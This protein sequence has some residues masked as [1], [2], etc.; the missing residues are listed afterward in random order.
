VNG[1]LA[2]L[3]IEAMADSG[4]RVLKVGHAAAA[5]ERIP[6]IM[7]QLVILGGPIHA[8]ELEMLTDR[9]VAVGAEL[10]HGPTPDTDLRTFVQAAK[11]VANAKV[12]GAR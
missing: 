5:S 3:L 12:K 8:A 2:A 6:V 1:P 10:V 4:L 11:S 9:C 7:P